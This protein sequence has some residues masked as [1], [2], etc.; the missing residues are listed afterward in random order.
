MSQVRDQMKSAVERELPL[1]KELREQVHNLKVQALDYRQCYAIAPVAT[2]G[3]E[4]RLTFDPINIEIV[5]VVDSDGQE[6]LQK[7]LPLSGGAE[8][9]RN[10]FDVSSPE[11]VPV[12][13]SLLER[14]GITY[15]ELSST[16]DGSIRGGDLHAIIKNFREIAEW[17]VLLEIAWN[18]GKSKVLVIHDGLL[19]TI[20]INPT[21]IPKLQKSFEE[22]YVEKGSLLVGVAKQSKVLNYLSLALALERTLARKYPC[23]CEVPREMEAKAYNWARSW[24]ER[25]TF[26]RMHLAKLVENPDALVFPVDIPEW[27]MGRRKEILEYLAETA[28]NS[29]PTLGYPEPLLRAHEHAVLYGLEMSVLEDLLLEHV[30]DALPAADR[31]R[32]LEH[33][34]LGKQLEKREWMEHG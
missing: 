9:I 30:L 2:D 22:A 20:A 14:L 19:R 8:A 17:A 24:L 3:G 15:N 33:V 10:S 25:S 28:K 34:A 16:L 27:L 32:A 31:S 6:R 21:V 29:F 11:K 7:I 4:N 12:L 18:P 26:G 13:V 1:L 23:F 5:R